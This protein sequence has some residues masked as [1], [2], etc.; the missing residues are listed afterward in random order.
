ME[1]TFWEKLSPWCL[2]ASTKWSFMQSFPTLSTW[3]MI[4]TQYAYWKSFW[5]FYQTRGKIQWPKKWFFNW[6]KNWALMLTKLL[7]MSSATTLSKRRL[8]F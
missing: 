8:K 1:T 6:S 5:E 4:K 2:F 7:K 3:S